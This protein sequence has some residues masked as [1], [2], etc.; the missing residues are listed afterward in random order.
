MEEAPTFEESSGDVR[1]VQHAVE[2][3]PVDHVAFE[4]WQEN[5]RSVA[6]HD[7]SHCDREFV[8]VDGPADLTPSP[9][10]GAEQAVAEDDDINEQMGHCAPERQGR[11]GPQI[12]Q[13]RAR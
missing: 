2:F 7:D 4:R 13:E 1:P 3:A 6:E 9:I 11:Y 10:A 12:S 5:L 8:H